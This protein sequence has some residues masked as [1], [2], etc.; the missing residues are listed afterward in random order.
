MENKKIAKK[1]LKKNNKQDLTKLNLCIDWIF[2]HSS[3]ISGRNI[4]L[5]FD[6]W[7]VQSLLKRFDNDKN[8]YKL[9]RYGN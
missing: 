7:G 5:K 9:R 4:S 6:K 2:K 1:I 3:K 8:L